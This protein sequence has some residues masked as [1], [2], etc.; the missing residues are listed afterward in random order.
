M[1]NKTKAMDVPGYETLAEVFHRAFEQ[2][3]IGKGKERHANGEPFN[4]QVMQTGAHRFGVGA[5]LFQA[6]KKS[7]ESQ[8][9][10]HDRAIAE[11]LGAMVY[12]AGAVIAMEAKLPAND[13]ADWIKWNG[14]TNPAKGFRVFVRLRDGVPTSDHRASE[15]FMWSHTGESFDIVEYKITGVS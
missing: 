9:L 5:L 8:R 2:A 1:E 6:F 10:P 7:E 11:L 3:A 12:L 4:K 14:G 15:A 13:N